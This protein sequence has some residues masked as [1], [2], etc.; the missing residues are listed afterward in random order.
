MSIIDPD[1]LS[2]N[3]KYRLL[4]GIVVPRPIA[5]VTTVSEPGAPVNAAPFSCFTF[6]CYE[7]MLLGFSV[8]R[9]NGLLKDTAVNISAIGEFV[10]HIPDEP[11]VELVHQSAVEYPV[12][13]SEADELGLDTAPSETIAVPRLAQPPIALECRHDRTVEFGDIRSQF[14][15]GRVTRIHIRSGLVKDGKIDTELLNPLSRLAGA[16]YSSIG[17]VRQL[18]SIA[19]TLVS[20]ITD[21]P[22]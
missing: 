19:A 1:T 14:I 2:A 4:T 7:P 10:V 22:A 11:L 16:C 20:E 21:N 12:E 15:V 8:G 18:A 6:V 5:W 17:P 13:V 9:K 3:A